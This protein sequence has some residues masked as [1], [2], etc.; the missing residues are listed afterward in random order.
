MIR[1]IN[2]RDL[3]KSCFKE[4]IYVKAFPGADVSDMQHYSMPTVKRDPNTIIIHCGTN[5]LQD[6]DSP[7]A[8]AQEIIDLPTRLKSD[9][10]EVIISSIGIETFSFIG[11]K[12]WNSLSEDLKNT[13]SLL[14][15]KS[16]SKDW[17]FTNCPC[18]ICRTYVA[19]VGY[20]D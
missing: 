10:N 2:Y 6:Y 11:P 4:K 3:S 20:L 5:S 18:S 15:F 17:K 13:K 7:D 1:N 14:S 8:F 16:K 9:D 19:G 12:I